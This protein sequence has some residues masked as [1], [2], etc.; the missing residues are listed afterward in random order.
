[1]YLKNCCLEKVQYNSSEM[2]LFLISPASDEIV[3]ERKKGRE[4]VG[5]GERR[6]EVE[7]REG[8]R[9]EMGE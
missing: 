5:A 6:Q 9:D 8:E 2:K 1:M 7:G 3:E 4:G